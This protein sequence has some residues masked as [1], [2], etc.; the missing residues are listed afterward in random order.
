MV[1]AYMQSFTGGL[2]SV[3]EQI[4]L[5][6]N[7]QKHKDGK[8]LVRKFTI[9]QKITRNQPH[10]WRNWITDPDD[11]ELFCSYNKQDVI[12]EENIKRRLIGFPILP[13]EWGYYELDQLINDRGIPVDMDFVENVIWMSE[14]RTKE[15]LARM[16]EITGIQNP[17]S[18]SQ[19]LPWLRNQ[20]YPYTDL[21]KESVEKTL[22]K[23]AE[24]WSVDPKVE[25]DDAP[26]VIK[27]L[28][29][30]Q[31]ASLTSVKKA[32]AAKRVVGD[33]GRAR[34]LFQFAGASRTNRFSG[35]EIQSQN[36]KRTPKLL[37]AEEDDEKL[38]C[39]TDM[40]RRGDYDN[41]D[42]MLQ[43]P[44]LG[45][46][47]CM[48]SLFRAPDG[49]QFSV[50]D[51]S[52]VES[53]GLA[54]VSRCERML[55]VFRNGRDVYKD[56]G[57]LF[58]QK[59]YDEITRAERQICKPPA[60]GCGYRLGPGKELDD[61]RKTGLLAYA[62]NMGVE[63]TIEEAIRAV[64]VFRS[65]YPEVPVFWYDCEKAI[66]Y[67]L[68]NHK[69]YTVGYVTF[70]WHKPYL[71]IRLPSGRNIFYY[72]PRLETRVYSTGKMIRK[73]GISEGYL[74]HG[75]PE[76]QWI[77]IEEEET[78]TKRILT[79][80]GRNQK[81]NQWTRLEGHGGVITENIVQAL[82]RDILMVGLKRLHDDGFNL[83]GHAHD[84]G[85]AITRPKDNFY[86]WER[87]RELM[88]IPIGW[89]PGFPL[90]AA[91]WDGQFYRK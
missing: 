85:M 25:D 21:R 45:L 63:M 36:M 37:D 1:L 8:R 48:R 7:L 62:E 19:L 35:R 90:G 75:A 24:I 78:Y 30:R 73:R 27:V 40:I 52:S 47:G 17:N 46:S 76:G 14:R 39:V 50:S 10:L 23:T 67:V 86:N 3:A 80:M 13:E 87:M 28:R 59:A 29:L 54:W 9:P 68:L 64:S 15:L 20:G 57:T 74:I 66:R 81:N 26:D 41:L 44:M 6:L 2:E 31:W 84:E 49:R 53:V 18:V 55:D 32:D 69:P 65:G 4:G 5:P 12:T 82:T 60:L 89:A 79:Y 11:W 71:L 58:Y 34:F 51:Y 91:G 88:I 42:L 16:S 72:K 22:K 83:V 70:D 56:F 61:G 38:T 33:D 77:T 43:E